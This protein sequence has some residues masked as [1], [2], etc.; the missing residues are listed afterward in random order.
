[1][2]AL[3]TALAVLAAALCVAAAAAAPTVPAQGDSAA[4]GIDRIEAALAQQRPPPLR[5]YN[6]EG[7]P[8][9]LD[10][11]RPRHSPERSLHVLSLQVQESSLLRLPAGAWLRLQDP[12]RPLCPG[13]FEVAAGPGSGAYLALTPAEDDDPYSLLYGDPLPQER[14]VRLTRLRACEGARE[15]ALFVSVTQALAPERQYRDRLALPLPAV[16][17]HGSGDLDLLDFHRLAGQQPLALEI[18]GPRQLA[19]Q[20]RLVYPQ[21]RRPRSVDRY[22]LRWQ[23]DAP[24][25][26]AACAGATAAD[27]FLDRL[28]AL[29]CAAR[30][31]QL[32]QTLHYDAVQDYGGAPVV[33]GC[34]QPTGSLETRYL[35]IPPGRHRF[36]LS[37]STD[38]LLRIGVQPADD[39]LLEGLNAPPAPAA[40]AASAALQRLQQAERLQRDNTH[41]EAALGGAQLL[42]DTPAPLAGADRLQERGRKLW[43][44]RSG[45]RDLLPDGWQGEA[46]GAY[47]LVLPE[48]LQP[49]AARGQ[50]YRL[51]PLQLDA[52]LQGLDG[53]YF[54]PLQAQADRPPAAT[55]ACCEPLPLPAPA[56]ARR[57]RPDE[58]L[59]GSPPGRAARAAAAAQPPLPATLQL[60][61]QL[62]PGGG[63]RYLLPPR[64]LPSRLR[65][66]I[67]TRELRASATLWLRYDAQ[68][69]Q[70]LWVTPQRR[71]DPH[72][73]APASATAALA[74]LQGL[75]GSSRQPY[76]WGRLGA[77]RAPAAILRPATV[78]LPLPPEVRE[79]QISSADPA[80]AGLRL[81]LQYR[82]STPF[83]LQGDEQLQTL[84]SLP[85]DQRLPALLALLKA[86]RSGQRESHWAVRIGTHATRA[87]AQAQAQRVRAAGLPLQ[88]RLRVTPEGVEWRELYLGP[89]AQEAAAQQAL[90]QARSDATLSLAADSAV[91]QL[92]YDVDAAVAAF[93]G[94]DP[95]GSPL[96]ELAQH[97]LPLQ[98]L[99]QDRLGRYAVLLP[100]PG[101]TQSAP[102]PPQAPA[103]LAARARAHAAAGE[104]LNALEDWSRLRR[105]T[106]AAEALAGE[107]AALEAMQE[108]FLA[109]MLLRAAVLNETD[110][111]AQRQLSEQLLARYRRRGA[112]AE[113]QALLTTLMASQAPAAAQYYAG[114]L[115]QQLAEDGL[116]EHAL[117]LGLLLPPCQ[118]PR[119]AML[120]AAYQQ[121][122]WASYHSLLARLAE[123]QRR[124]WLGLQ[125]QLDGDDEAALRLWDGAGAEGADYAAALRA[126]RQLGTELAAPQRATREA[127]VARWMH[128]QAAHPGPWQWQ[129]APELVV[130]HAGMQALEPETSGVLL[131]GFLALPQQPLRLQAI[132]PGRLR[133]ELRPL[134]LPEAPY[135]GWL[136]VEHNGRRGVVVIEH[137][138]PGPGLGRLAAGGAATGR[139]EDVLIELLPGVNE[140]AVSIEQGAA[141]V[142]PQQWRPA[143]PLATLPAPTPVTLG[144]VMEQAWAGP[145]ASALPWEGPP[146]QAPEA[147]L[148]MAASC[149]SDPL[150]PW[151][152]QSLE[153]PAAAAELYGKALRDPDDSGGAQACP[154][155]QFAAP[156]GL[157]G[158]DLPQPAPIDPPPAASTAVADAASAR[159]RLVS[160]AWWAEHQPGSRAARL[161]Q[162]EALAAQFPGLPEA[163][164][165]LARLR[166][167]SEWELWDAPGGGLG[168]RRQDGQ[169][170]QPQGAALR[171]RKALLPTLYE[172]EV[173][174]RG[175][176]AAEIQL[177]NL[178][179]T[180]LRLELR[181]R[182]LPFL[183]P[184]P[185]SARYQLDAGPLREL[186]LDSAQ[187]ERRL[188]LDIGSGEHRLRIELPQ[189]YAGQF[190]GL[191]VI[192]L[193]E[194][195]QPLVQEVERDFHI[196]S[197]ARPLRLESPEPAW[198]RIDEW[199]GDELVTRYRYLPAGEPLLLRPQPGRDEALLRVFRQRPATA[200]PP[201]LLARAPELSL[202]LPAAPP[203]PP[204]LLRSAGPLHLAD[205]LPL[206]NPP[207]LSRNGGLD[208]EDGTWG[209]VFSLARRRQADETASGGA[210]QYGEWLLSQRYHDDYN[211][212]YWRSDLL[213][214]A[215]EHGE[216]VVGLRH[217]LDYASAD[218][219]WGLG[220]FASLY[221]QRVPAQDRQGLAAYLRGEWWTQQ[222]FGTRL[223]NRFSLGL[224]GRW[225]SLD[226]AGPRPDEVDQD[227]FTTFKHRQ[228]HGLLLTDRVS[229]T[230]WLDTLW[231]GEAG[232]TST[233][234][235]NLFYPDVGYLRAGWQQ[236]IGPCDAE[237]DYRYRYF[238]ATDRPRSLERDSVELMLEC[239][240]WSTY[241][242]GGAAA[243]WFG[244][245]ETRYDWQPGAS[246][247]L[248]SIGADF[249]NGRHYRDYR[250]G[251]IGFRALRSRRLAG[252]L[253]NNVLT[254]DVS[255]E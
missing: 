34:L 237:L 70:R 236:L 64:P 192:E 148:R 163:G 97:W 94:A 138:T 41:R 202:P 215:R 45:Y 204:E 166:S 69:P 63:P 76:F 30:T 56:M 51:Q 169:G 228:H 177:S 90:Q 154:G 218:Q 210:E 229:Y 107:V 1:V 66:L 172:D 122:D 134:S 168:L 12:R 255:D 44:R 53:A 170:W 71:S 131:P 16:T 160:L 145:A 137:N 6:V 40:D 184:Q 252:E 84:A 151:Q 216:P 206:G 102:P 109:E 33:E 5:W 227:V 59:P 54:L 18:E 60:A 238:Y 48:P 20:T 128:W 4:A 147:P 35:E 78:E 232:L 79:L 233:E 164:A 123:P 153:L 112:E 108:E 245:L 253:P 219:P 201:A 104:W 2:P 37:A 180:R 225:L 220:L 86:D 241:A 74:L 14:V 119:D 226:R 39:Y 167:T 186:V 106:T 49:L 105:G 114:R 11:P 254:E 150:D 46:R 250:A 17:L 89:Y 246:S 31:P 181:R 221:S 24:S 144:L 103:A 47:A 38:L 157:P 188:E 55:A 110:V 85:L 183:R 197:K 29:A 239:E 92:P 251:E 190:L 187:A 211:D 65:L 224:F 247:L 141:L 159:Q 161:A 223:D 244:R 125:A 23:V 243:R 120:R 3:K 75:A 139:G 68:P 50:G 249:G 100:A 193:G 62:A 175:G 126:G 91:Q 96:A 178:A 203:L 149:G 99:L 171:T 140:L 121:R 173:P 213:L 155:L 9:W 73:L 195:P 26:A 19:V 32:W 10:G 118:Q 165:A 28:R 80:A 234:D 194:T 136:R 8:Y 158:A 124:Y 200:P 58:S 146:Q 57:L 189:A 130:A 7:A 152:P 83:Q 87:A 176:D 240:H 27:G 142:R 95:V 135:E 217:W 242:G 52:L 209:G 198:L 196:A 36:L 132:G 42:L 13:E 21:A 214:R 248:L 116:E 101:S 88:Q 191:R 81:A 127:A 115:V 111:L 117:S 22:W 208:Q 15:L 133:L 67:D 182:E 199:Q 143:L 72:G 174:L 212:R 113:A 61:S 235:Y 207:G 98:R 129:A 230:P 162:A 82:V 205:V 43:Q 231:F 179:P 25:G 185:M 77:D 156:A 222:R 93:A